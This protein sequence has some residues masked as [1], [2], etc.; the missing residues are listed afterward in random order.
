MTYANVSHAIGRVVSQRLASLRELQHDY[1]SEDFYNLLE[2]MAV[3]QHNENVM[4]QAR[5]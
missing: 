3:D 2:I 4:N 1:S 5:N